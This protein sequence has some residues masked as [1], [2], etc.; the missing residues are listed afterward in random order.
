MQPEVYEKYD[1]GQ[2]R[3]IKVRNG[4]G[5]KFDY[6]CV[7]SE[8]FKGWGLLID[9]QQTCEVWLEYQKKTVNAKDG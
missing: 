3:R 4:P 6:L 9:H 2:P 1:N 5:R 7:C 8:R